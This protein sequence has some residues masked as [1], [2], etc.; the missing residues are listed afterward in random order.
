MTEKQVL[1]IFKKTNAFLKG[2]FKLSSGLHSEGYLQC[3]LVL[4]YPKY[5]K[6]L[7]SELA[8]KFKAKKPT[9]VAAPAIGGILVSYEVA[10]TLGCR[11]VFTERENGAMTFR[12][13]FNIGASD[14]V[15][16]AEDVV[17]TGGS[18]KE[19][20]EAVKQ[21]GAKVIGVGSIIDR[22]CN[23]ID[24]GVEFKSILKLD[25]KTYKSEECPL[26]KGGVPVIK[27]GSRTLLRH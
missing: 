2:H 5:A 9:V 22:S 1:A 26:C 11:S 6:A 20:I 25:A 15:L 17:T 13:G 4:Q 19:V 16:V 21:N 12:R 18:T 27:P 7:C 24:F 8:K 10:N 3:A 23:M 14:R